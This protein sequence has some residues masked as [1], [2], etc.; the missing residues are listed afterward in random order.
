MPSLVQQ[1]EEQCQS[2]VYNLKD[3]ERE[4]FVMRNY[5]EFSIQEANW[6]HDKDVNFNVNERFNSKKNF[7]YKFTR[8][9]IIRFKST[10]HQKMEARSA[11]I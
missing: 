3:S 8:I 7:F 9:R 5:S 6:I 1:P 10:L 4:T 11:K 2:Q